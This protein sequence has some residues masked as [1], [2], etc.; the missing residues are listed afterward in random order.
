MV[1][2]NT[3]LLLGTEKTLYLAKKQDELKIVLIFLMLIFMG[4]VMTVGRVFG[5]QPDWGKKPESEWVAQGQKSERS[6]YETKTGQKPNLDDGGKNLEYWSDLRSCNLEF[7][8]YKQ[9]N[10]GEKLKN[11]D[12]RDKYDVLITCIF[13]SQTPW[14]PKE[15]LPPN[16]DPNKILEAGKDPGLG[17]RD[18][19]K[20]GITGQGV[21]SNNR[22]Q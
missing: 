1:P 22:I 21:G 7:D 13:D 10:L 17:I 9:D 5:Q 4:G 3:Q 18:L 12:L 8:E 6:P 2:N 19:H 15:K 11:A 14:P 16:F 20:Q